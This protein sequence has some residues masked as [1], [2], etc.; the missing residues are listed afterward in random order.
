MQGHIVKF[1]ERLGY[2]VIHT[3]DGQRFRFSRNEIKN[4]NGKLVGYDVDFLL[5]SRSPREI[6][7]MQG[8]PWH[9]F[10]STHG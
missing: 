10:G 3:E 7:L 6:F 1:H 5:E 9:A 8:S 2:G 4:P